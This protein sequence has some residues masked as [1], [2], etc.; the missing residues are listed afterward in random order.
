MSGRGLLHRKTFR[1]H[2]EITSA[3]IILAAAWLLV[4]LPLQSHAQTFSVLYSFKGPP[5]GE[6][7][8]T[9]LVLDSDGNIYGTTEKGG[10]NQCGTVFKI[11]KQGN[12]TVLYSFTC[13][14]DGST[15]EGGVVRD[16]SG[17]L[18]GTTNGGGYPV[19]F[20]GYGCG[21]VFKVNTEGVYSVLYRFGAM[22][23]GCFPDWVT[24]LVDS[25]GNL[26]GTTSS[27]GDNNC[28]PG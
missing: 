4:A 7:P 1:S 24:L 12:E 5:D 9:G 3:V 28:N 6:G 20:S 23:D 13:A 17:N 18:Y 19:G 26:F 27:G 2:I 25:A 21:T 11:D 14:L 16:A 10:A 8:S 22:P 15:P